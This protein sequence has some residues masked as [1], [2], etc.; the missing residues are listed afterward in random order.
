MGGPGLGKVL[1]SKGR[2]GQYV[3]GTFQGLL[4]NLRRSQANR[5]AECR[6]MGRGLMC[7]QHCRYIFVARSQQWLAQHQ[8]VGLH[9][10]YRMVTDQRA[11]A[12]YG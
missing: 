1:S 10:L 12:F 9:Q 8:G 5:G 3:V 4:H 2:V 6:V 7:M 11:E